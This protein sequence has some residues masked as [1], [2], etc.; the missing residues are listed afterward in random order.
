M[1]ITG[2]H[3]TEFDIDEDA[4]QY[5]IGAMGKVRRQLLVTTQAGCCPRRD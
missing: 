3:T 4:L 5:A 2:H 1:T